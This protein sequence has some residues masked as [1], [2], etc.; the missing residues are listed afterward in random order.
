MKG[1]GSRGEIIGDTV[2]VLPP[3][4][5][6]RLAVYAAAGLREKGAR[7]D[8][9]LRERTKDRAI[10]RHQRDTQVLS[11]DNVFAIVRRIARGMCEQ[12]HSRRGH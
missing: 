1:K 3:S 11:E 8:R 6:F 10:R 4:P 9:A 12:K 7:R 5:F 2:S